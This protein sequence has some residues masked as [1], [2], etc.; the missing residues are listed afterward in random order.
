MSAFFYNSHLYSINQNKEEVMT[1][2]N[3]Q[4]HSQKDIL[5]LFVGKSIVVLLALV[6]IVLYFIAIFPWYSNVNIEE[7]VLYLDH[8]MNQ[9]PEDISYLSRQWIRHF[10]VVEIDEEFFRGGAFDRVIILITPNNSKNRLN[11]D[12]IGS[13]SRSD[14]I[15]HHQT[16]NKFYWGSLSYDICDWGVFDSGGKHVLA[17]YTERNWFNTSIFLFGASAIGISIYCWGNLALKY[18]Q[19]QPKKKQKE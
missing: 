14:I 9:A 18:S 10:F 4:Q 16:K 6:P 1:E 5:R 15:L 13:D 19:K 7:D 17:I 3:S 2:E 8:Y 11:I 12:Y